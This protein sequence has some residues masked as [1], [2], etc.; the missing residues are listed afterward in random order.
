MTHDEMEK[1]LRATEDM[2]KELDKR[3]RVA[4][5]IEA[6]KKLQY[7]YIHALMLCEWDEIMD[8]FTQNSTFD[9]AEP[10]R[11]NIRKGKVEI[12]KFFKEVL[13]DIHVGKEGDVMVHPDIS[14]DGDTAT[15]KWWLYMMYSHPQTYQSLLWVQGIYDID[16]VKVN[17]LWK[18]NYLKFRPRIEPP[19]GPPNPGYLLNFLNKITS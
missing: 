11:V 14:V 7:R 15:G 19:D 4:E 2:V 10:Q 16:Y 8:M 5:D 1:R 6:I 3:L 17:E 13:A 18:F 9:V 12:E